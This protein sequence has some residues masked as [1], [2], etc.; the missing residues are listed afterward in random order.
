M[1]MTSPRDRVS[2]PDHPGFGKVTGRIGQRRPQVAG[3]SGEEFKAGDR[4]ALADIASDRHH[5]SVV[6]LLKMDRF[7]FE[8]YGRQHR[9]SSKVARRLQ[10]A[11][12][13]S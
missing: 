7:S 6:H 1:V 9:P 11:A 10:K 4:A 8:F 2:S 5:N 12:A 3:Q 13:V